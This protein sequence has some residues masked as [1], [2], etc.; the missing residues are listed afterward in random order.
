MPIKILI[1]G[2]AV[3]RNL[4]RL[5]NN[6]KKYDY[7][8]N[9][10]ID[11]FHTNSPEHNKLKY[12]L[13]E[14]T[15][16]I[17]QLLL[18]TDCKTKNKFFGNLLHIIKLINKVKKIKDNEYDMINIHYIS[19]IYFF[20]IKTLKRKGK[21]ILFSPW[22]S[23]VYRVKGLNNWL[24]KQTYKCSDIVSYS[25]NQFKNDIKEKFLV[26]EYK[27]EHLSFGSEIFDIIYENN[28]LSREDAKVLLGISG[29]VIVCGYN[30]SSGQQHIEIINALN[31]ISHK[32][33]RDIILLFPMTYARK[34][35]YICEVKKLL[36]Q[37]DYNYIIYED[38]FNN[39]ELLYLRKCA[40]L[41]IHIPKTDAFSA[42]VQEY[43]LT[44]T[45]IILGSWLKYPDLEKWSVPYFKIEEISDLGTA[46][47]DVI[48]KRYVFSIT[49]ELK[50]DIL[51][52]GYKNQTC[53]WIDFYMNSNSYL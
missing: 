22:G 49:D 41:F 44:D 21:K 1:I 39:N 19:G 28:T 42:T 26:P 9:L 33:Q 10:L 51:S 46:I 38:F 50:K 12:R 27:F 35:S 18:I 23:D 14:L 53:K 47:D 43:L 31:K 5:I 15:P 30:A 32:L 2:S 11:V 34:D 17:N 7:S 52:R 25:S 6:L 36:N 4:I 20:I 45:P 40:D 13:S 8:E 16:M 29:F 24:I 3:D 37:S 48:N